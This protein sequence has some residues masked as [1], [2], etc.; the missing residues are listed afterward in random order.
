MIE[1]LA[2]LAVFLVAAL[3]YLSARLQA[4]NDKRDPQAE[5]MRLRAAAAWHEARLIQ[6]REQRY[7]DDM[8]GRIA[9]QLA[10]IEG[11]LAGFEAGRPKAVRRND[12]R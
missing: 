9:G 8:I 6:A 3:G 7:D 10:E 12:P 2:I 5:E 1:G 11:R 4:Q